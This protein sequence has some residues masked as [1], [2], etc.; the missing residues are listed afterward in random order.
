MPQLELLAGP[1]HPDK[2]DAVFQLA[3]ERMDTARHTSFLWLVPSRWQAKKIGL[4]LVQNSRSSLLADSSVLALDEWFV[5]WTTSLAKPPLPAALSRLFV[6][7]ALSENS[8]NDLTGGHATTSGIADAINRLFRDL[9]HK[10]I[11]EEDLPAGSAREK[12][13]RAL[14]AGYTNRI[15]SRWNTTNDLLQALSQQQIA[16]ALQRSSAPLELLIITG[17]S[18][19]PNYFQPVFDALSEHSQET[20]I[21]LDYETERPQLYAPTESLYQFAK[22]RASHIQ[23]YKPP[24]PHAAQEVAAQ[25]FAR[26]SIRCPASISIDSCDD[27]LDETVYIARQIRRL[28]SEQN[29]DLGGIRIACADLNRY[30]PLLC[31]VLPQHGIPFYCARGVPL[32][33]TPLSK[34]V[35]AILDAVLENYSRRSLLRLLSL[36]WVSLLSTDGTPF[37]LEVFDAW[38]RNLPPTE[39]RSGWLQAVDRRSAYLERERENLRNGG[40]VSEDI[41]DPQQWR[42]DLE[43]DLAAL[44][45]LRGALENLFTA[46]RPFERLLAIDAFRDALHG[47][48]SA[49]SVAQHI[50]Q[51]ASTANAHGASLLGQAHTH[52]AHLLDIFSSA[53]PVLKR[54]RW[55]TRELSSLLRTA[56]ANT[57]ITSQRDARG[58]EIVDLHESRST[59]CDVL[60]VGG[61]NEGELPRPFKSD[62]FFDDAQRQT[63]HLDSS[64]N[65]TAGDRLLFYQT[66]CTPRHHLYLSYPLRE[67]NTTLTRS[68][69][70]EEIANLLATD[71]PAK[72]SPHPVDEAM[73]T[74]ADLHRSI[75]R[76]LGAKSPAATKAHEL[77]TLGRANAVLSPALNRLYHGLMIEGQRSSTSTLSPYDGIIADEQARAAIGNRLGPQHAFSTTQLET[78]G[79]C[80]FRFFAERLLNIKSLEDPDA[81][82]TAIERGNLV[83]RILYH[84]YSERRTTSG[85]RPVNPEHLEQDLVRMRQIGYREAEDMKLGG[86]FWQRELERLLG[87]GEAG[88]R[89]G[90]IERFLRLE[91]A[92]AEPATPTHFELSFG[93]YEGMG[94]RDPHSAST[95]FTIGEDEQVV[96]LFGKIDRIDRTADSY[97]IIYDYKTGHPPRVS[98]IARGLNL[99]LPLYLL[100]VEKLLGES[101]LEQG[102]AAAYLLLRDLEECGRSALFADE[103]GRTNTYTAASKRGLLPHDAFR[104]ALAEVKQHAISYAASMRAGIFNVTTHEPTRVCLHCPYAQSCRLDARRMRAFKRE[105]ERK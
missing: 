79:R 29:A 103:Q 33:A 88:S 52:F 53:M 25:L 102:M 90:V 70:V 99:Q 60:F 83:H 58:V 39:G 68:P 63:L 75:G 84:F 4:R 3:L 10:G 67:G 104:Q 12:A 56:M 20:H 42:Q 36:P 94:P 48:F 41:D 46:L 64:E 23:F 35:H 87:S 8:A 38:A 81:D 44:R 50:A 17:F 43:D 69:F 28:H 26:T 18:A 93:S 16:T 1:A 65:S 2:L 92:A 5:D 97:F 13:L 9:E 82:T 91:A 73:Y 101:G 32:S 61:L 51:H 40:A 89:E 54:Q 14:Y 66:C 31:E 77:F 21:V 19:W 78:Y 47:A 71:D 7:D 100:A 80:P 105:G 72:Q 55:S 62:L 86:F 24:T 49:F 45:P 85:A 22:A 27:R 59:P 30:L 57:F 37:S 11:K 96:R 76:G 98:D 6:E 15:A 74:R 95:A 34:I